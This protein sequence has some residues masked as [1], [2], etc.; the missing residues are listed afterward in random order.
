MD[1]DILEIFKNK[2]AA[3]DPY[4]KFV[5][6]PEVM[7]GNNC[8]IYENRG[9]GIPGMV[10]FDTLNKTVFH[11]GH[12]GYK[13]V[14]FSNHDDY[15]GIP[16]DTYIDVEYEDYEKLLAIGKKLSKK[17]DVK[18][19]DFTA[20]VKGYIDFKLKPVNDIK[21][22]DEL[23]EQFAVLWVYGLTHEYMKEYIEDYNILTNPP[24][25]IVSN[26]EEDDDIFESKPEKLHFCIEDE[27]IYMEIPDCFEYDFK[28]YLDL[29][30]EKYQHYITLAI[31]NKYSQYEWYW[32][33]NIDYN[34]KY[35]DKGDK[36]CFCPSLTG[37]RYR[38][39]YKR[40]D[41]K[42]KEICG[43]IVLTRNCLK[44]FKDYINWLK[45]K[46]IYREVKTIY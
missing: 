30:H 12:M 32:S 46:Y 6:A 13:F 1:F 31:E 19:F 5:M 4:N 16:L 8:A 21:E 43:Y 29:N 37:N 45:R 35:K 34:Y 17:F 7:D 41:G 40:F 10:L 9:R 33:H 24:D 2:I 14:Y 36:I 44:I 42:E 26:N 28:K 3:N 22:I 25:S 27:Y 20:D 11:L 18:V 38:Y 39:V 23:D 15:I